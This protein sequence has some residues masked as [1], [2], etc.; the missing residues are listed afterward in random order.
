MQR[1][2]VVYGNRRQAPL[3]LAA[4]GYDRAPGRLL[5]SDAG[6]IRA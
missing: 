1:E 4:E 5:L 6:G 2:A 3:L